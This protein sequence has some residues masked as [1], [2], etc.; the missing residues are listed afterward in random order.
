VHN[1]GKIYEIITSSLPRFLAAFTAVFGMIAIL[2]IDPRVV[3]MA[4]L[5]SDSSGF[6]LLAQSLAADTAMRFSFIF[7]FFH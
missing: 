4:D 1:P 2:A 3:D 7:I 5:P 6:R